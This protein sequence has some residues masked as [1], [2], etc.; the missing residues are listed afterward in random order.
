MSASVAFLYRIAYSLKPPASMSI[1]GWRASL[2]PVLNSNGAHY[3]IY[4]IVFAMGRPVPTVLFPSRS[5][6]GTSC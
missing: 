4:S 5:A 2:A 1:A 6:A 3:V